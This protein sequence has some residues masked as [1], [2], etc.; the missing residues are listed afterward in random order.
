MAQA[1]LTQHF[2]Y[3]LPGA[4][5][6]ASVERALSLNADLA[7]AHAVKSSYLARQD[8]YPEARAEIDLALRLDPESFEVNANAAYLCF[9]EQRLEDAVRYYEAASALSD[10]SFGAPAMLI[11]CYAALGDRQGQER[12]ARMTLER[13]EKAV[14]Q[15]QS[16][17]QAMG[18]AAGAMG[19]LGDLDGTRKWISRAL[20]VDPD[21]RAMR[22]NLACALSANFRDVEGTLDLLRPYVETATHGELG[23]MAVDPDLIPLRDD[24]R[25]QAMIAAAEARLAAA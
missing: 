16:N 14:E 2:R 6:L 7:E 21:N 23:H 20:T 10:T 18:F 13:A 9:R 24:D 17:G 15:D 12:A 5:G 19:A 11:T 8:R 1:Q 3:G 22:Y 25:F 4:D